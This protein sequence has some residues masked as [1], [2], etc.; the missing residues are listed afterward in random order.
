MQKPTYLGIIPARG[1]SKR[2]PKKN[3]K[4]ING[5]PLIAWTIQ[6]AN[7]SKSL[8]DMIVST[9]SKDISDVA[10]KWGANVPYM[11]DSSIAGDMSPSSQCIEEAIHKMKELYSKKFEYVV[12]LQPT[13]PCRNGRDID[14][15]IS[16]L[17]SKNADCV[18]SVMQT[19]HP[20][21]WTFDLKGDLSL[22]EF[23]KARNRE[24]LSRSQDLP[25]SYTLNGAIYICRTES[26]LENKSLFLESNSYAYTMDRESSVD[27]DSQFDFDFAEFLMEKYQRD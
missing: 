6:A 18:I 27:I 8:T 26:F 4:L 16:M 23:F 19:D 17:E 5:K 15:A 22:A 21:D 9:D 3:I 12:V 25:A 11:R 10:K 14:S 13:S 7:D 2:L 20:S 24:V 1:G